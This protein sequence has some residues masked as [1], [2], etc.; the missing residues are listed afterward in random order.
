MIR[1]RMMLLGI[2]L[3][4]QDKYCDKYFQEQYSNKILKRFDLYG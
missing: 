2:S 1:V 4:L 3:A